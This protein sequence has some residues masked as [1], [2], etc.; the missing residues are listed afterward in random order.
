MPKCTVIIKNPKGFFYPGETITGI[1]RFETSIAQE[2][3]F[4][5]IQFEGKARVTNG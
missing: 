3:D 2:L 5:S 4:I 1:V